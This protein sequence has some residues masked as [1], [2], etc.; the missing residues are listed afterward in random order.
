MA[1]AHYSLPTGEVHQE[2]DFDGPSVNLGRLSPDP[3]EWE[4]Q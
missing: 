1:E 4:L 3:V 2:F